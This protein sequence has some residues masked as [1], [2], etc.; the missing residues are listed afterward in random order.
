MKLKISALAII[1]FVIYGLGIALAVSGCGNE[2]EKIGGGN[3]T[4]SP[5]SKDNVYLCQSPSS[6]LRLSEDKSAGMMINGSAF[7]GQW[8][9]NGST[10]V[11]TPDVGAASKFNVQS[12]G[13]LQESKYGFK[14]EKISSQ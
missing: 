11:F 8:S 6:T 3:S 12:D 14:L 4:S 10:I 1:A 5:S 13:S 9:K 2:S 7:T